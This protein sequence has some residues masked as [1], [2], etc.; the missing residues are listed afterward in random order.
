[1]ALALLAGSPCSPQAAGDPARPPRVQLSSV[2]GSASTTLLY[3]GAGEAAR[4]IGLS[5]LPKLSKLYIAGLY[6]SGTNFAFDTFRRNCGEGSPGWQATY[7]PDPSLIS[8]TQ[9]RTLDELGGLEDEGRVCSTNHASNASYLCYGKHTDLS[10]FRARFPRYIA[11]ADCQDCAVL[12]I[13]RHPLWFAQ[14]TCQHKQRYDCTFSTADE[15]CPQITGAAVSCANGANEGQRIT[16][17]YDSLAHLWH[18]W[19]AA[20][21]SAGVSQ[22][23]RIFVRYEDLLFRTSEVVHAICPKMGLQVPKPAN[24][25]LE[26]ESVNPAEAGERGLGPGLD[27]RPSPSRS[28]SPSLNPSPTPSPPHNPKQAR[29]SNGLTPRRCSCPTTRRTWRARNGPSPLNCSRSW[30]TPYA[31]PSRGERA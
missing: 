19:H 5:D 7:R 9:Q 18:K 23:R 4:P 29:P 25:T 21:A 16:S 22:N 13:V 15:D 3:A 1:M 14:S 11:S 10:A 12:V 2:F 30:T 28:R 8:E 26:P 20:Y 17:D 31:C 27:P 24:V 6:N